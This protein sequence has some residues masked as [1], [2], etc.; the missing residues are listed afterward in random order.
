M[1]P[2]YYIFPQISRAKM[3]KFTKKSLSNYN[4]MQIVNNITK[5][6]GEIALKT[7]I[8]TQ[9]GADIL[10]LE[11]KIAELYVSYRVLTANLGVTVMVFKREYT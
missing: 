1:L 6:E 5:F 7:K 3:T 4:F 2:L 11:G 9:T 8:G 10:C